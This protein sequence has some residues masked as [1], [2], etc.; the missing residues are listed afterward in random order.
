MA[1]PFL[2]FIEVSPDSVD[3]RITKYSLGGCQILSK[4]L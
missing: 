2:L 1:Y 4:P 3:I